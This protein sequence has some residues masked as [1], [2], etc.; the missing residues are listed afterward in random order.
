[1]RLVKIVRNGTWQ[2]DAELGR[3]LLT[4]G[5]PDIY[6]A[7]ARLVCFDNVQAFVDAI[8]I[9]SPGPS[10]AQ[11]NMDKKATVS[12][13]APGLGRHPAF[14]QRYGR[15]RLTVNWGGMYIG[16]GFARFVH[17]LSQVLEPRWWREFLR[18]AAEQGVIHSH[19][20]E[21]G[22]CHACMTAVPDWHIDGFPYKHGPRET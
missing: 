6:W 5:F 17:E 4:D 20:D 22:I 1:M 9:G 15:H 21:G 7:I 16:I 13:T 11:L 12:S 8:K 10:V 3:R 14:G 18:L 2:S 19:P